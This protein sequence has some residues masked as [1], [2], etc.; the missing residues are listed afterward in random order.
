M[1]G[2]SVFG[3]LDAIM[4]YYS[5][6]VVA[7]CHAREGNTMELLQYAGLVISMGKIT[8]ITIY[9]GRAAT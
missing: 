8:N 2:W 4:V 7:S 9:F 5:N 1:N 3:G 6:N